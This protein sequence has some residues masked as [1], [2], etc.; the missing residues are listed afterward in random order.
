[1]KKLLLFFVLAL[2]ATTTF[3]QRNAA[4]IKLGYFSPQATDGG[5]IIGYQG[6]RGIDQFLDIGWSIDW[7][8]KNY[9][10]KE[11]AQQFEEFDLQGELNE[12]RAKTNIHE[13]PIMFNMTAYFD[14]NKKAAAFANIG[15][16]AEVLLVFYR[17]YQN[18]DED[19]IKGAFDFSWRL[20]GGVVYA[21]GSRS[22]L[23]AELGY[24]SSEPSWNYTVEGDNGLKK[25]FERVYDMSG[26]MLRVGVK[27]YY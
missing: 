20:S 7:F 22:E 17:N 3:G 1:M 15:V 10:D 16:G 2:A 24:H 18:P 5:F 21:M 26:V 14:I 4:A 9:V 27:F 8:N 23:L 19:K 11:L 12:L 6:S 13:V 25:T